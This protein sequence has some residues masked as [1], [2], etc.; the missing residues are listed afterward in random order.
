MDL[1]PAGAIINL[2]IADMYFMKTPPFYRDNEYAATIGSAY[3]ATV[4]IGLLDEVFLSFD[5]DRFTQEKL[6]EI[7]NGT[8]ICGGKNDPWLHVGFQRRLIM[9]AV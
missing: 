1:K 3:E 4:T 8:K 9:L 5:P 6:G 2:D 7:L